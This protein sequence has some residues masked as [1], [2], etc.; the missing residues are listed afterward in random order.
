M[1]NTISPRRRTRL[2]LAGR[3]DLPPGA[4]DEPLRGYVSRVDE[5]VSL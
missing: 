2:L 3:F 5:A 1:V 4:A